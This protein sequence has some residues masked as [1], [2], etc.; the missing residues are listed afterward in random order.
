MVES[1]GTIPVKHG[2]E[3]HVYGLTELGL[4]RV[5][6]ESNFN[7][8]IIRRVISVN[9]NTSKQ[10]AGVWKIIIA[11]EEVAGEK[12]GELL[13]TYYQC[14]IGP[15]LEKRLTVTKAQK[16]WRR[17]LIGEIGSNGFKK[18]SDLIQKSPPLLEFDKIDGYSVPRET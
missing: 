7:P 14:Y 13:D 18:W 1:I 10:A 2:P 6:E 17:Y 16:L 4:S 11:T 15:V 8:G 3:V 12:A 5:I 9:R